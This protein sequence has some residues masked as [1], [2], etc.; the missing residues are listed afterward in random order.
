[1]KARMLINVVQAQKC[2]D[3]SL[4]LCMGGKKVKGV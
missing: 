3:D 4:K 1:M 2:K